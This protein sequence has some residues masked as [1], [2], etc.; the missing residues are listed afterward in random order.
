MRKLTLLAALALLTARPAA[1][2]PITNFAVFGNGGVTLSGTTVVGGLTGSNG[3]VIANAFTSLDGTTGGG[4]LTFNGSTINVGATFNGGVSIGNFVTG[5]APVNS[6]GAVST[7]SNSGPITALGSV[8]LSGTTV[9]NV[10]SGGNVVVNPFGQVQGNVGAR[11]SVTLNTPVNPGVTGNVVYGTTFNQGPFTGVGGS[12]TQ[13]SVSVNPAA[14]THTTVPGADAFSAG[15]ANVS[16]GTFQSL[17][18]APGSYGSLTLSGSSTLT[19]TSGNYFFTSINTPGPFGFA[20]INFDLTKG[21]INV[22]VTGN[23]T[24]VNSTEENVLVGGVMQ[25][26]PAFG[27][28]VFF[29]SANG[30]ISLTGF[31][32]NTMFGTYFAPNGNISAATFTNIDGGLIAAGTVTTGSGTIIDELSPRLAAGSGGTAAVPE[33]STLALFG[34][35]AAALAGWWRWRGQA[36]A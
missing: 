35:G 31:A 29:E 9:G 25:S 30:N 1:A 14:Y 19:L 12:V 4:Q 36:T 3:D 34:L 27:K 22:F 28:Q 6:L 33:P 24:L 7:A 2:D 21:P 32:F 11:G 15:G 10:F 20:V 8:T 16:V 18:L 5:N 23:I 13:G 17:T 26:D